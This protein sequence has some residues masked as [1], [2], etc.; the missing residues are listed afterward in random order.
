M[1]DPARKSFRLEQGQGAVVAPKKE[2][3]DEAG[4]PGR[5]VT[6]PQTSGDV[7]INKENK[8]VDRKIKSICR[9]C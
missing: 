8:E 6:G 2:I 3:C 1:N 7:E 4:V 9:G 5:G